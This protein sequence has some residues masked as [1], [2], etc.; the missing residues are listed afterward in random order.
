MA[1]RIESE[2]KKAAF[3]KACE[4]INPLK[5]V[6]EKILQTQKLVDTLIQDEIDM[7]M[8]YKC[9]CPCDWIKDAIKQCQL[10]K[11][12][13]PNPKYSNECT[14]CWLMNL[15]DEVSIIEKEYDMKEI[16]LKYQEYEKI[17]LTSEQLNEILMYLGWNEI[18]DYGLFLDTI[19]DMKQKYSKREG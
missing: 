11:G 15:T 17:G 10:K 13:K 8:L 3:I 2:S 12:K 9:G 18:Y 4:S 19:K 1:G 7:T 14:T 6:P 5:V 16:I